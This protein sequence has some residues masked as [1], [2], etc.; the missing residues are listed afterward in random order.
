MKLISVQQLTA[1]YNDE[2]VCCWLVNKTTDD[3]T[4]M[5]NHTDTAQG[6]HDKHKG[7]TF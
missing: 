6:Q 4:A 1:A 2:Q 5:R 7:A 3:Y